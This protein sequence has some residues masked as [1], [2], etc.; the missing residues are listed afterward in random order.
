LLREAYIDSGCIA[1]ARHG[2][3]DWAEQ[4]RRRCKML[5]FAYENLPHVLCALLLISR[6]GDIG[7]TYLVSPKLILEANPIVRKLGW[8]FALFTLTACLLPYVSLE[9]AVMALMVFLLVSARNAGKIWIARTIGEEVYAAFV[10]ELARKS[11]PS[12]ALFGLALST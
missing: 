8:P 11:K 1:A 3:R 4:R 2:T 9:G 10:L 6:I 7:T 12:H 5:T